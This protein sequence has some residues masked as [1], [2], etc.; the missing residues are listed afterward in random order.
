MTVAKEIIF[1]MILVISRTK[2]QCFL[3]ENM[4]L[5]LARADDLPSQ[6]LSFERLLWPEATYSNYAFIVPKPN[7][8]PISDST[9][10]FSLLSGFS[11]IRRKLCL[12]S[13]ED[14]VTTKWCTSAV[15]ARINQTYHPSDS[16]TL[17]KDS[18][19]CAWHARDE[20]MSWCEEQGVDCNC[21]ET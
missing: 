13:A 6:N 11:M 18:D 15:R 7:N 2:D 3:Q 10:L 8:D 21:W 17:V 4:Y 14:F 5:L 19:Y 12:G 20:I 1:E 16:A 9:G